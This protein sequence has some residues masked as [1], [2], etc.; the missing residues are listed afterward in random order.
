MAPR[1]CIFTPH[2][3]KEQFVPINSSPGWLE[4]VARLLSSGSRQTSRP[5]IV[6]KLRAEQLER[7]TVLSATTLVHDTPSSSSLA[8]YLAQAH[9]LGPLAPAANQSHTATSANQP[10]SSDPAVADQVFK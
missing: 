5:S 2:V 9:V 10:L 8:D 7:R 6:R 1:G 3:S 4:Q